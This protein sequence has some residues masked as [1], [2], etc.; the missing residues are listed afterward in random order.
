MNFTVNEQTSQLMYSL[1]GTANV[2]IAGNTTLT[3]LSNGVHNITVFAQ[4]LSGHIGASKT[5]IFT[6]N[7]PFPI[8]PITA[9]CVVSIVLLIAGLLVY[10]KKLKR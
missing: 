1:D 3:A 7:L 10:H 4:D 8:L 5:T 9:V 6:V 2:T